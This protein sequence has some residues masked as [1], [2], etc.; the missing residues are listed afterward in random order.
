M[1][2]PLISA[3]LFLNTY[4]SLLLIVFL[5]WLIDNWLAV[6]FGLYMLPAIISMFVGYM[7]FFSSLLRKNPVYTE[8]SLF[9]INDSERNYNWFTKLRFVLSDLVYVAVA[10]ALWPVR[11]MFMDE[12]KTMLRPYR[13]S[14]STCDESSGK[15]QYYREPCATLV[16]CIFLLIVSLLGIAHSSVVWTAMFIIQGHAILRLLFYLFSPFSVV[17]LLSQSSGSIARRLSLMIACD[18][19]MV[20]LMTTWVLGTALAEQL[21]SNYSWDYLLIK[22]V[23]QLPTI[24]SEQMH[25]KG[26]LFYIVVHTGLLIIMLIRSAVQ[27]SSIHSNLT[28]HG[29]I[30]TKLVNQREFV[31]ALRHI[32][33]SHDK[34]RRIDALR[35]PIYLSAGQDELACLAARSCATMDSANLNPAE[36]FHW[37][38]H[39]SVVCSLDP[40][41]VSRALS[42]GPSLGV[43]D[44]LLFG[45]I[46]FCMMYSTIDAKHLGEMLD[47]PKIRSSYPTSSAAVMILNNKFL[48]AQRL[49]E[50]KKP[51]SA[52]EH[53]ALCFAKLLVNDYE[54]WMQQEICILATQRHYKYASQIG[55]RTKAIEK[56]ILEKREKIFREWRHNLLPTMKNYIPDVHQGLEPLY[57]SFILIHLSWFFLA[58]K[59]D[60]IEEIKYL[61][62]IS[63]RHVKILSP[64]TDQL[65][66][67]DL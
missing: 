22:T 40:I 2:T 8:Y 49:V 62:N 64:R 10:S 66:P 56:S 30:A 52:A 44:F 43:S 26:L 7:Y 47:D 58:S 42:M 6:A 14:W 54:L 27:M 57:V 13:P 24:I 67:H 20:I 35:I 5:E 38:V 51:L 25:L 46:N 21:V 15:G 50:N 45:A 4:T 16:I 19:L 18:S 3:F 1:V 55:D 29:F 48:K 65:L 33:L 23:I 36:P 9:T 17:T 59:K 12:P 31:Q 28:N 34:D 32:D 63:R 39:Y 41:A 37:L 61:Y 53:I 11:S 60:R